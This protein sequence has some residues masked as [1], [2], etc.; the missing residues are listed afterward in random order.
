MTANWRLTFSPVAATDLNHIHDYIAQ[1]NPTR[2]V[3]FVTELERKC[4]AAA[5]GPHRYPL[6]ADIHP[7]LRMI[8]HRRYLIFFTIADAAGAVRI[9]RILHSAR[10]LTALFRSG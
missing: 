9:E 4:A 3:S 1:D 5:A 10:D 2:A 8:V 7:G 6:R